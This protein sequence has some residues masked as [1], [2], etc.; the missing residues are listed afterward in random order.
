VEQ[1]LAHS[2][3]MLAAV[4]SK[5]RFVHSYLCSKAREHERAASI[6]EFMDDLRG[7]LALPSIITDKLPSDA[8]VRT[9]L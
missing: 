6:R 4:S 8:Q 5:L 1:L 9:A 2:D 3:T 7:S